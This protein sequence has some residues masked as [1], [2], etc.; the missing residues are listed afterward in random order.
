MRK[1]TFKGF[2]TQY[3]KSLSET[4]T[5]DVEKLAMEAGKTNARL[6]EP[7][8]LY[9]VVTGKSRRLEDKLASMTGG[10]K[11]L[12]ELHAVSEDCLTEQLQSGLLP[13]NYQKVW[14]S[15]LAAQGAP[16]K[17]AEL[18]VSM[19]NKILQLQKDKSCSNYRIYRD[20]K[21]N[22]GNINNWLKNGD[23]R[24][25]SYKTAVQIMDYVLGYDAAQRPQMHCLQ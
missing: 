11:M 12:H 20:L 2:L 3:V 15:F 8:I 1:L 25:V 13:E 10:E 16:R 17:E 9:A 19:R 22:P 18:K 24:K 6:R 7:L 5:L 4:G 14:S 23:S 21:L